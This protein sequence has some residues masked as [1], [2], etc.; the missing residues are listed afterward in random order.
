M[1]WLRMAERTGGAVYRLLP[2]SVPG[3]L[4]SQDVLYSFS[5]QS[6][7]PNGILVGSGGVLY[8][9]TSGG[10]YPADPNGTVFQLSP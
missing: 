2:P 4:W 1:A 8:G 5:S 7:F 6:A 10:E 3:T 9:T